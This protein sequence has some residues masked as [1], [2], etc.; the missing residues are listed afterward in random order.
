MHVW[1]T[2]PITLL[3]VWLDIGQAPPT[4]APIEPDELGEFLDEALP[5]IS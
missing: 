4:P 1:R 5:P 3:S 2:H